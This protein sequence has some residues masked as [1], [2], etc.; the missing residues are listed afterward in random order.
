MRKRVDALGDFLV[1]LAVVV[2]V[3]GSAY[4]AVQ[5]LSYTYDLLGV[6][7]VMFG[8]VALPVTMALMPFVALIHDHSWSLFLG[9][10]DALMLGWI[11]QMAGGMISDR[12]RTDP[13]RDDLASGD[14]TPDSSERLALPARTTPGEGPAVGGPPAVEVGRTPSSA[15]R[16]NASATSD[17]GTGG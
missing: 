14:A 17:E 16:A 12:P 7:W 6:W 1:A 13:A 9:T 5:V 11:L 2:W 10:W 4:G 3:V 8:V 15:P